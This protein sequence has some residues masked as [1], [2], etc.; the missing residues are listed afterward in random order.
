MKTLGHA[1]SLGSSSS[2]QNILR[3]S[4]E[5]WACSASAITVSILQLEGQSGFRSNSL[6]ENGVAQH[7]GMFIKRSIVV[8]PVYCAATASCEM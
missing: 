3:V 6:G 7:C 1:P 8:A 2:I 4:E 5:T